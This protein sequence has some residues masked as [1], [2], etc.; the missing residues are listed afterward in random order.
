M[1]KQPER[2]VKGAIILSLAGIV[3]KFVS[4]FYRIPLVYLVGDEGIG[5]YQTVFPIFSILIAAG[6]IGIPNALS[7]LIAEDVAVGN[8][9]GARKT[10]KDTLIISIVFGILITLI[11]L[12]GA[13]SMIDSTGE[14][15]KYVI[16][17]FAISPVFVS[18]AGAIK[19]YFQGFQVMLP[20]AVSQIIENI[21]KVIIGISLVFILLNR[22]ALLSKAVGGAAIGTSIGFIIS[23]IFMVVIFRTKRSKYESLIKEDKSIENNRSYLSQLKRIFVLAIPVSIAAAVFSVMNAIDSFT[24]YP[25]LAKI[26]Y[27]TKYASEVVGQMAKAYSVINFP[28]TISIA[29]STSIIPAISEAA[30]TKSTQELSSKVQQG[31]KLAVMLA[32]PAAIGLFMLAK[33]I[34]RMLYPTSPGGFIYLQMFSICLV[35]MI[36]GQTLAG[37]LQG[38]S[39]QY[40]PIIALGIA[41]I[42]KIILNNLL[43]T[44]SLK[45]VGAALAS[46]AYYLVILIINYCVLKKHISFKL[47]KLS[48]FIKPLIAT[49]VMLI[50]VFCVFSG[51]EIL[52]SNAGGE[53]NGINNA[54][55]TL[56]TVS[57]GII[58]YF[59]VLLFTKTFTRE[60]LSLLPKHKKIIGFLERKKL[61]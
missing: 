15:F 58:F 11:M 44:T 59:G 25:E 6:F 12:V 8:I 13:K 10:F 27:N 61:L 42:V 3:A 53:L 21:S 32:L 5:L 17:G 2:F 28:L 37:I 48:V 31:L 26:G 46:I 22:G 50:T 45:G 19:G 41:I 20:T 51:L 40:I 56:L 36:V 52:L 9:K 1:S 43:I 24:L 29:L 57:V 23:A 49:I 60:E 7:K 14:G 35:F 55:A 16:W 33:P 38:I 4:V 47:D 54:I 34:M 30:A 18:I 39:K